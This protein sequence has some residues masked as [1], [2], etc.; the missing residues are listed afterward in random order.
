MS[1]DSVLNVQRNKT[2]YVLELQDGK[3]YIGKKTPLN[4]KRFLEHFEMKHVPEN[5]RVSWVKK[6]KAMRI[7]YQFFH[8][9]DF[10]EDVY[11]KMFMCI[12]G[13][14]NVRG[15]SYS[16]PFI[17][18]HNLSYLE[19][20]LPKEH[21]SLSSFV[22]DKTIYYLKLSE[23]RYYVVQ[24]ESYENIDTFIE[25]NNLDWF[26]KY[27]FEKII[28]VKTCC[29][30]LEVDKYVVISICKIGFTL[31]NNVDEAITIGSLYVRG[32]SFS[33]MNATNEQ[34]IS[35]KKY[36]MTA[37]DICYKCK[38]LGHFTKSCIKDCPLPKRI[39]TNNTLDFF[40]KQKKQ[41]NDKNVLYVLD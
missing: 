9:S 22:H 4:D 36:A 33:R 6:H 17:Y 31:C 32:G 11:T 34:I 30:C 40:F 19:D 39:I 3:Y 7:A 16:T 13:V 28:G 14:N 8:C 10:D 37:M 1:L 38:K 12:Y 27:P 5:N 20:N 35:L 25:T 29:N 24:L 26:R 41:K 15:G 23:G 21:N 2:I 18:P